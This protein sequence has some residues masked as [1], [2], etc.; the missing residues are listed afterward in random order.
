MNPRIIA[1]LAVAIIGTIIIGG[2]WGFSRTSNET[3]KPP[4]K[5]K[6][7]EK[8]KESV[9]K[10]ILNN[11]NSKE[12]VKASDS[13]NYNG[14]REIIDSISSE[15][16]GVFNYS[17]YTTEGTVENSLSDNSTSSDRC[18]NY[19]VCRIKCIPSE[20]MDNN[21]IDCSNTKE[22]N[23]IRINT[24][25]MQMPYY[26]RIEPLI[27]KNTISCRSRA[28]IE[29]K[30]KEEKEEKEKKEKE[31]KEKEAR[32]IKK[33]QDIPDEYRSLNEKT[34]Q[35]PKRIKERKQ[36]EE[37]E[38][39]EE[40]E[41]TEESEQNEEPEQNEESEQNEEPEQNE[42]SIKM[43]AQTNCVIIPLS[44]IS[45]PN[46]K[47]S[48]KISPSKT[49]TVYLNDRNA[50]SSLGM[51]PIEPLIQPIDV[52]VKPTV[53]T[54]VLTEGTGNSTNISNANTE[55]VNTTAITLIANI[56]E[57]IF[58]SPDSAKECRNLNNGTLQGIENN[59]IITPR[60][61]SKPADA[62]TNSTAANN[63]STVMNRNEINNGSSLVFPGPTNA[64]GV[65]G[66]VNATS[67]NGPTNAM[68]KNDQIVFPGPTNAMGSSGPVN[69]MGKNDQI[70]F[71]GPTNAMSGNGQVN[72]MGTNGSTNATSTN[73][74][75]LFPG[76]TNAM[77]SSVPTNV[78]GG[79]DQIV[80]P[81]PTNAMGVNGQV[82]ATSTNDQI[83]FPGPTNAMGTNDQ[84]VFPGPTNAMGGTIP[85]TVPTANGPMKFYWSSNSD[86]MP[87]KSDKS[88]TI[89]SA[90]AGIGMP[91]I[92]NHHL[93]IPTPNGSI[94]I[95]LGVSNPEGLKHNVRISEPTNEELTAEEKKSIGNDVNLLHLSNSSTQ[96]A[97]PV[98]SSS[99]S[100]SAIN[101][102]ES[103]NSS[104]E[105]PITR[106]ELLRDIKHDDPIY[107]FWPEKYSNGSSP[108][109]SL[110]GAPNDT[111]DTNAITAPDVMSIDELL[112]IYEQVQEY[113]PNRVDEYLDDYLAKNYP[114]NP[115]TLKT[116]KASIKQNIQKI[117][118]KTKTPRLE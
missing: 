24:E 112:H 57:N 45:E 4:V 102:E 97:Q 96:P 64:M 63:N 84:I 79:N 98:E 73:D 49:L 12:D 54:A 46:V 62:A 30:E 36:T 28:Y 104:K 29:E 23:N 117:N 113:E 90:C 32:W 81:G 37:S 53:D 85:I 99:N 103:G 68:G 7:S 80:F 51:S 106:S 101:T 88:I 107:V 75:I 108:T 35:R 67:I 93:V 56:E 77:G 48:L 27:P 21:R 116:I 83:V 87:A 76:P 74:Q 78:M 61:D 91:T 92:V 38:Q 11:E 71:P 100:T 86:G 82:N 65:N 25:S 16:S 10:E 69:V 18:I 33:I 34:E 89:P 58:Q 13:I 114:G 109:E 95:P 22:T 9:L 42:K 115:E 60:I 41:Q 70:V 15:D 118:D 20:P 59:S 52:N 39:N 26:G 50:N 55:N 31:E 6:E 43:N 5:K 19:D 110:A 3:S 72:A 14:I 17:S 44:L 40:S 8:V 111:D 1:V 47:Y 2:I 94:G 66:Q 105:T